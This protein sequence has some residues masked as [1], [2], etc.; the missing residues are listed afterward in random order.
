MLLLSAT[1]GPSELSVPCGKW[2][3]TEGWKGEGGGGRGRERVEMIFTI[4]FHYSRS[5]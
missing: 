3:D 4:N 5:Y 2:T 1:A